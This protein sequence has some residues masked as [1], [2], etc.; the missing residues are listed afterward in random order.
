MGLDKNSTCLVTVANF[1]ASSA[2][3]FVKGIR[4]PFPSNASTILITFNNNM[5][6][7]N[8]GATNKE[9]QCHGSNQL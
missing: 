7:H 1:S 4:Q 3:P 9:K 2:S 5:I 6:R 8:E